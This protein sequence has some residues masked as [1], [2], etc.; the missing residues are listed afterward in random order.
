MGIFFGIFEKN[1][2]NHKHKRNYNL[3]GIMSFGVLDFKYTHQKSFQY[4]IWLL[5]ALIGHDR[6]QRK[7]TD[8]KK[9]LE[10]YSH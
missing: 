10:C 6:D 5:I 1:S 7:D 2:K 8:S 3:E 9:I 4:P